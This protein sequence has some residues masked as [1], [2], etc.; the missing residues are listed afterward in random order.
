MKY[1]AI[2]PGEMTGLCLFIT[3]DPA[4]WFRIQQRWN[5]KQLYELLRR[6]EPDFIICES[7]TYQIRDK[8]VLYPVELIGVVKLY[9]QTVGT[10]NYWQHASQVKK[11][12]T[13]EKL[14]KLGLH[15]TG[16]DVGQPDANDANDATRHMLHYLVTVK[17]MYDIISPLQPER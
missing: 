5:H 10:P 7:F 8:V 17:N 13:N 3:S 9:I 6:N 4:K 14:K 1:M 15:L 16:K 2:D 12:W 11:L